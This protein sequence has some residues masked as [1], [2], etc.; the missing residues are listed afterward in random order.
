MLFIDLDSTLGWTSIPDDISKIPSH[1]VD[2]AMAFGLKDLTASSLS[3]FKN[4]LENDDDI[5][6]DYMI[7]K[8]GYNPNDSLDYSKGVIVNVDVFGLLTSNKGKTYRYIC[9]MHK[10]QNDEEL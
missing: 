8:A 7:A 10:N 9:L 1:L 2:Y 3:D 6:Y 4:K 5:T